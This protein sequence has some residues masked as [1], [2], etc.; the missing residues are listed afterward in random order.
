MGF[1]ADLLRQ[2]AVY[3]GSPSPDGYGGMTF[4]AP[5]EITVRW[6]ERADRFTDRLGAEHVSRA[7]VYVD[8]AL[9]LGGYLCLSTL[10]EL[11]SLDPFELLG[12]YEIRGAGSIPSVDATTSLRSVWL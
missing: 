12:A 9:D 11:D 1:P 3:W 8:R 2:T 10:A 6:E 7:R 4:A 5:I